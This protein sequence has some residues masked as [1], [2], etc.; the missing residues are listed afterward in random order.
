MWIVKN[1]LRATLSLKGLGVSIAPG[2]EF[3][4]DAI[5]RDQAEHSPQVVVA[6]E[7]GYLKNVH[8]APREGAGTGSQP[9]L[10]P[11][12]LKGLVTSA[13]FEK[14]KAQFLDELKKQLPAL[15]KLEQLDNLKKLDGINTASTGAVPNLKEELEGFRKA[16]AGDVREVLNEVQAAKERI[17]AEKRKILADASL[18]E[19]E[20]R[21]RLSFLDDKE[22][23]LTKNFDTV[24][25]RVEATDGDVQDKADLLSEL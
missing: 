22:R 15:Q 25:R 13:D 3:D 7:E 9:T 18:S 6:F 21:A 12:Q 2:E 14:F 11:D 4:L 24:G 17:E 16:I 5:G 20:I 19:A 10:A 8:K 1:S 23:E